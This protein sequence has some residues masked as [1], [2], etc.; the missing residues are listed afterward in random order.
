[1]NRLN[2][3]YESIKC[4]SFKV[5]AFKNCD[6]A[7]VYVKSKFGAVTKQ[8]NKIGT[9]FLKNGK[10]VAIYNDYKKQLSIDE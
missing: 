10:I 9:L 2:L 7:E 5:H 1:M 6:D 8:D 4:E 3:I